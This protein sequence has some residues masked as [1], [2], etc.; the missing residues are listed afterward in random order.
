[1][2]PLSAA[3]AARVRSGPLVAFQRVVDR[4]A[5]ASAYLAAACLAAL[6]LLTLAEIATALLSRF[7]P[8]F[9]SGI[10]IAWEYSAYLMG[11]AFMFGGAL[12]LRAGMQI[13]VELLLRARNGRFAR[14]LELFSSLIGAAFM[15][16]LAWNLTAFAIQSYVS[17]QVSGDS[18]T[19]L[20]IPQ[21]ALAL[22]TCV[23]AL[24]TVARVLACLAGLPL[25]N[26]A[27]KVASPAE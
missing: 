11:A 26:E 6:T 15:V 9:P 27:F 7:I 20:W 4:L 10:S 24:Q 18:M 8:V 1:V 23:F 14:P 16:F 21:A 19:P 2:T 25:D 5:L 17:G 12:T 22:A 3:G 13:R